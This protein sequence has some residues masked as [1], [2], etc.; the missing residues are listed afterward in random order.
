MMSTLSIVLEALK[1]FR[2][3]LDFRSSVSCF[4][5]GKQTCGWAICMTTFATNFMSSSAVKINVLFVLGCGGVF[6]LM[7]AAY[8]LVANNML[9]KCLFF[10]FQTPFV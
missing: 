2:H 8:V 5:F 10:V 4:E 7:V 9:P 3:M 6:W 1:I